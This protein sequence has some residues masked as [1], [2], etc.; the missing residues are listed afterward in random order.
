MGLLDAMLAIAFAAS[1]ASMLLG[2]KGL[3]RWRELVKATAVA[4]TTLLLAKLV[5]E[6]LEKLGFI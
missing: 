4:T 5:I 1:W 6:A 3:Q 2:V